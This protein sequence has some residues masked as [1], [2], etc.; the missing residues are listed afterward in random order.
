VIERN[1]RTSDATLIHRGETLGN[2]QV[3]RLLELISEY[4]DARD[5]RLIL[6]GAKSAPPEVRAEQV[7]WFADNEPET[8]LGHYAPKAA[9]ADFEEVKSHWIAAAE[10]HR[11]NH[12]V[13][14]NAAWFMMYRDP[15]RGAELLEERARRELNPCWGV[16]AVTFLANAS[17][18]HDDRRASFALRALNAGFR[19]FRLDE[20]E[21]GG[22]SHLLSIMRLCARRAGVDSATR[23]LALAEAAARASDQAE[24]VR[25]QLAHVIRAFVALA[26]GDGPV[27][28][29]H[30]VQASRAG[31]L[32]TDALI[33]LAAE[34]LA[35]GAK[36]AIILEIE[37][38][39]GRFR[40]HAEAATRWADAVRCG[41]KTEPP[42]LWS[43]REGGR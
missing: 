42:T 6:I 11:D 34:L 17:D 35:Q 24:P 39:A 2:A 32:P 31:S 18:I 4:P 28:E 19:V 33:S 3:G 8:F 15:D 38:W 12:E 16:C 9:R 22:S 25:T 20:R 21:P 14:S 10:R 40:E 26:E 29:A 5:A 23:A 36:D 13:V 1:P 43:K 7:R 27:A 41:D 30:F 37:S